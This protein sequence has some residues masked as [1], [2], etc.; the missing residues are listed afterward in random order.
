M[1]LG[2]IVELK[3]DGK[4]VYFQYLEQAEDDNT[5]EGIRLFYDIY[6]ERPENI[7]S[8][9]KDDFLF[10]TFPLKYGV[11]DDDINIVGNVPLPEDLV[12]PKLFRRKNMFGSG[13]RILFKGGGS[14]V[15][16]EL[17]EEQKKYPPYGHW[18]IPKIFENLES[19]WRL[20]NWI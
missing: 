17:N 8:V 3:Q 20:E 11:E 5:L 9:I 16:E 13:W 10:L 19:G 4:K 7:E 1:T 14:E 12:L 2:D 6:T 15:V 18:N